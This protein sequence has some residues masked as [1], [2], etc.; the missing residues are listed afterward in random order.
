MLQN[1]RGNP[2]FQISHA[3]LRIEGRLMIL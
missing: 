3:D 2:F 1:Q